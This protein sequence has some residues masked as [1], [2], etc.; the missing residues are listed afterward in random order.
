MVTQGNGRGY[1]LFRGSEKSCGWKKLFSLSFPTCELDA[2]TALPHK[3]M[4]E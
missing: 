1:I 4:Q 3:V 2:I